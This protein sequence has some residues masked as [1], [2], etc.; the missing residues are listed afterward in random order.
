MTI[1]IKKGPIL[2]FHAIES[3]VHLVHNFGGTVGSTT[4][5]L[6]TINRDIE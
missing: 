1:T 4:A 5:V 2:P 6:H 3:H